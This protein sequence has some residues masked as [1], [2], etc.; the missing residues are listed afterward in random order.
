M[1]NKHLFVCV[2]YIA[3]DVIIYIDMWP[4]LLSLA[5]AQVRALLGQQVLPSLHLVRR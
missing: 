3:L 4:R 5:V 2:R 1:R